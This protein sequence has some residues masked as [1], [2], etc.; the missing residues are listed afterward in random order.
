MKTIQRYI[1]QYGPVLN[2]ADTTEPSQPYLREWPT[3]N[4]VLHS[5]YVEDVN[6]RLEQAAIIAEQ[7]EDLAGVATY[8]PEEIRKLKVKL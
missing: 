5:D 1:A 6:A 4:A 8:A 7:Q 2:E 3:G